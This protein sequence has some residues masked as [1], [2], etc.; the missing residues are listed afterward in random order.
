[1]QKPLI[2]FS[3]KSALKVLLVTF[4]WVLFD[5][6][7][8]SHDLEVQDCPVYGGYQGEVERKR[9][10]VFSEKNG[11]HH[12]CHPPFQTQQVG[13]LPHY[14]GK[15]PQSA[16]PSGGQEEVSLKC[17]CITSTSACGKLLSCTIRVRVSRGLALFYIFTCTWLPGRIRDRHCLSSPFL[18]GCFSLE[19]DSAGAFL[20]WV[21]QTQKIWQMREPGF[22]AGKRKPAF[23]LNE[24]PITNGVQ[25]HQAT[26]EK[27]AKLL[28]TCT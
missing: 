28:G 13:H 7:G 8:F 19:T 21:Q 14:W 17:K 6:Q 4:C 1:M 16:S 26:A 3:G 23:M 9:Q 24:G 20:S 5:S 12:S 25:V 15:W 10:T 27:N 18:R 11:C 22:L 2:P